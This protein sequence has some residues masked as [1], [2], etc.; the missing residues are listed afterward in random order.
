MTHPHSWWQT[1]VIYQI[2]PRSFLDSNGDGVGD[3]PGIVSRLDYLH[4]LGVDV[5][6]L[7]PIYPSPMADFGYD[8]S[9]YTDVHPLFGTLQDLDSLLEQAHQRD[10]KVILDF[11]PN[12]TSDEH[13]WFQEARSSRT[14][15]KRDWYIWR[16]PAPDG[17]PPN[18]WMSRFG[19]SA[20]QFDEPTGQ[21]YLHLYDVKQ[22]DLNWRNPKVRQAMYEVLRF[23]L[24]RD[25]DGFRIDA[26]EVL[27]KDEQFRDNPM[28]PEWKPGDPPNT[29]LIEHYIVDQPGMHGIMQEM[30]TLTENYGQ[31]VLIGELYLP[32]ER[33]MPYYGERLDEIHLPFNFQ[34]VTMPTWEASTIRQVVDAYEAA[35][36]EGAWPNW[37]LGNHDR[38]RIATRV[39]HEQARLTQ[40]L[41]LTLRGTP[42]CYYGE[43]LGMQDIALPREVMQDPL[44]REHPEYSRDPVRSP[45]QWDRSPNAGFCPPG[46]EPWLPLPA[47]YQQIN[48]AV[49]RKDPHSLLTLTRRLIELRRSTL[50]LTA[51]S[52]RP[53][54]GVPDG[55]F[56]YLRQASSQR[57]LVALNFSGQEQTLKLSEMGHGRIVLSTYLDREEPIDLALLRLRS[58]EGNVIELANL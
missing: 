49:E 41:L 55:C 52:Y 8:I 1:G 19:G 29:R 3:L 50:A 13:P 28:N 51:G 39:G 43:E 17:G 18:N 26:L 7:S 6:W 32:V 40:M 10:L 2:Y 44:A 48:V 35:L 14:N 33:L 46:T 57:Y 24:E 42:T 54:E 22:P 30:R 38:S 31:R 25:V 4:W 56:V 36:P 15:E 12:H 20:W 23:W 21:Y 5:L 45:M 11:V 47:D 58:D 53:I 37:V 9:N 16:D 27:L 34:F